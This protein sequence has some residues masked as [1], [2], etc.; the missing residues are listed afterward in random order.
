MAMHLA[1]Y[2]L[3]Q[4]SLST[5]SLA[6]N[7]GQMKVN[8]PL[9]S[10]PEMHSQLFRASAKANWSDKSV[11]VALFSVNS[12][13]TKTIDHAT[14]TVEFATPQTWSNEWKRNAYLIR[15]RIKALRRAVEDGDAH[16]LK[17]N[18]VYKLFSNIVDYSLEYQ[19]MQEV[20]L[21]S[22]DLEA[23]ATVRFQVDDQG[24]YFNPQWI[25]SIGHVAGFIMN[26]SDS[27]HP[28]AEVFINHGWDGLKCTDKFERGKTYHSYN[29]MQLLDGTLYA[30]D[31]YIFD[32]DKII[33][34]VQGIKVSIRVLRDR[35]CC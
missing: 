11:E 14:C 9:V 6:M 15:S 20:I 7:V 30:G 2:M 27:P 24:F 31:T 4:H 29:R 25:D 10:N 35:V 12:Q 3:E 34:V 18:I 33:A 32:G 8:K 28:M 23:V 26:G 1:N 22:N 5:E 19:G 17:R 16:R 13:G 21:D